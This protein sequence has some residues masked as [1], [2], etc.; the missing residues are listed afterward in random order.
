MTYLISHEPVKPTINFEGLTPINT[1]D[2]ASIAPSDVQEFVHDCIRLGY[3]PSTGKAYRYRSNGWKVITPGTMGVYTVVWIN[4]SMQKLHR[5][6][7]RHFLNNGKLLTVTDHVDHRKH[8]DGTHGQDK[9]VNLR[10]TDNRGNHGNRRNTSSQYA[11]V[12]WRTTP[13]KWRVQYHLNGKHHHIGLFSNELE[14]AWAY[15]NKLE[16]LGIDVSI[17]RE[18][19]EKAA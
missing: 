19:L 16:S 2:L 17:A 14:A 18:K 3:S 15:V 5:I 9:L 4:G 7:A 8:A 11:G 6:V 12:S 1:H 10:I 13:H